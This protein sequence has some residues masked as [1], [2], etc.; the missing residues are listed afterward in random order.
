MTNPNRI[1]QLA[2]PPPAPPAKPS[3]WKSW[4]V[5]LAVTAAGMALGASCPLWPAPVQ[6]ICRVLSTVVQGA[7]STLPTEPPPAPPL[8][9]PRDEE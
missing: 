8:E 9:P 7:A 6:P 1:D 4:G 5:R 3:P 2:P